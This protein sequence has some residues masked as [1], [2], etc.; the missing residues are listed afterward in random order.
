V[1]KPSITHVDDSLLA[2]VDVRELARSGRAR[3]IR[4]ASGLSLYDVAGSIG[5]SAPV[6]SRWETG[7]RRPYGPAALR[8]H[9]LLQALERR[10]ALVDEKNFTDAQDDREPQAMQSP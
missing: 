4:L 9:A 2:L 1:T 7:Q 10:V 6:L 5:S 8:W 3:E